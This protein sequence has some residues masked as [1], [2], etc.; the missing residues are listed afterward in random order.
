MSQLEIKL[1]PFSPFLEGQG[2]G[3]KDTTL[4]S[5][6]RFLQQPVP[7]LGGR[8]RGNPSKSHLISVNSGGIE[9]HSLQMTQGIARSL[10]TLGQVLGTKKNI[11]IYIFFFLIFYF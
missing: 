6:G 2:V 5:H 11:Y 1:Q 3:M 8:V 9:K 10:G 7:C 4:S